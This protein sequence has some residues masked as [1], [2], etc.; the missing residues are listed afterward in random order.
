M[1]PVLP[2][3]HVLLTGFEPFGG[4]PTNA[5]WTAVSQIPLKIVTPAATLVIEKV[6]LPVEYAPVQSIIPALHARIRPHIVLH[7]GL[8][9][10]QVCCLES[11][12]ASSGYVKKDNAG[13]VPE[14]QPDDEEE[15]AKTYIVYPEMLCGIHA[16]VDDK[17]HPNPVAISDDAGRF[18]CEYTLMQSLRLNTTPITLFLHI[19]ETSIEASVSLI[20]RTLDAAAIACMAYDVVVV[21]L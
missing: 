10:P 9:R 8:G 13:K 2:T 14:E 1:A 16:A 15:E 12:A 11:R 19:P 17:S 21:N 4:R 5:S 7:C 18:L 20:E 3:L 6:L